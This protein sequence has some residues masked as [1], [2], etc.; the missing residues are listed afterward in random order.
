MLDDRTG[1]MPGSPGSARCGCGME[2]ASPRGLVL[3]KR[4]CPV[5]RLKRVPSGPPARAPV[6]L[7]PNPSPPSPG[8]EPVAVTPVI[9]DAGGGGTARPRPGYG[10][11]YCPNCGAIKSARWPCKA[12]KEKHLSQDLV[13]REPMTPAEIRAR[14]AQLKDAL[15]G[16]YRNMNEPP[17]IYYV[18][19]GNSYTR[20]E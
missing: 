3:H 5:E 11:M 14:I 19:G 12:C 13:N 18:P 4:G 15:L 6:S 16:F 9:R 1:R 17:G 10:K 2:F 20:L 8:Q 7:A